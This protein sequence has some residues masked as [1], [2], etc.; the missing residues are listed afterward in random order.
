[1]GARIDTEHPA[2]RFALI[3]VFFHFHQAV[4]AI[5]ERVLLNHPA[6]FFTM[7]LLRDSLV[8]AGVGVLIFAALDRLRRSS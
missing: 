8:T 2:S 1:V 5:S 4:F 6:P 7:S 3:F